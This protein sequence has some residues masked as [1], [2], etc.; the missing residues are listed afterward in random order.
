MHNN[1]VSPVYAKAKF[2]NIRP[3]VLLKIKE[4]FDAQAKTQTPR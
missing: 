1:S 4:K 2:D 3:E